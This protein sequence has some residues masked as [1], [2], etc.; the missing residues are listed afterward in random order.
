MFTHQEGVFR[1]KKC[2]RLVGNSK[3]GRFFK[4]PPNPLFGFGYLK[5][6]HRPLA[7]QRGNFYSPLYERGVR[8]NSPLFTDALQKPCKRG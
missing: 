3:R 8:G 6:N 1:L 5:P 4:N 7:C 2:N